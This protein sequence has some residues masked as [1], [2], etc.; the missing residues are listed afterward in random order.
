MWR[1]DVRSRDTAADGAEAD[2][3]SDL[4][5]DELVITLSQ[6][7]LRSNINKILTTES[8]QDELM[9]CGSSFEGTH[10]ALGAQASNHIGSLDMAPSTER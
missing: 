4:L 10:E 5:V 9:C 8:Y 1:W 3:I 2:N 6:K 7:A